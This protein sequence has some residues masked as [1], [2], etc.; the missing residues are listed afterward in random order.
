[1]VFRTRLNE[2]S[3]RCAPEVVERYEPSVA[4]AARASPIAAEAAVEPVCQKAA[5][6]RSIA[7][8]DSGADLVER[9]PTVAG[10]GIL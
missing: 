9:N 2:R 6:I 10:G 5:V 1:M 3:H 8:V 7:V 4:G